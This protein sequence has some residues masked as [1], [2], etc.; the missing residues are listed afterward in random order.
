MTKPLGGRGKKAPYLTTVMRVPTPIVEKVESLINGY[1]L[2][3]I[4]GQ[5]TQDDLRRIEPWHS[6]Y[7]PISKTEAIEKAREILS[8]K[9]SAKVSILKLLQV[10]YGEVNL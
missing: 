10:L 4:H 3:A 8:Q 6:E 1:R 9:K 7:T 5:M 2:S